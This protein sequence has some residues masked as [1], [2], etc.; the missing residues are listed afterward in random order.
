M[1]HVKT[2]AL[3]LTLGAVIFGGIQLAMNAEDKTS[4]FAQHAQEN[5]LLA[6]GD[7]DCSDGTCGKPEPKPQPKPGN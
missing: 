6:C 4:R 7:H 3:S 2:I 1:A 5:L